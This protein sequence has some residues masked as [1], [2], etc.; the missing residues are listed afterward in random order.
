MQRC[1]PPAAS[2]VCSH[3]ASCSDSLPDCSL[4]L[5]TGGLSPAACKAT[6]SKQIEPHRVAVIFCGSALACCGLFWSA[7]RSGCHHPQV[8]RSH[9]YGSSHANS[10]LD[11][12]FSLP[13]EDAATTSGRGEEQAAEYTYDQE[14][15]DQKYETLLLKVIH[16]SRR[17]GFEETKDFPLHV[18]DLVAG[19]YQVTS[20]QQ[21]VLSPLHEGYQACWSGRFR[22][23]C[24]FPRSELR[25]CQRC[26]R[27]HVHNQV[28]PA[29]QPGAS[30]PGC[31]SQCTRCVSPA[32]ECLLEVAF[33]DSGTLSPDWWEPP[34]GACRSWTSWALPPSAGLC[35]RWTPRRAC[36]SA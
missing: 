4:L 20:A 34:P 24:A 26:C 10:L 15:I 22:W 2:M 3:R 33:G 30:P 8:W 11:G 1:L 18:N 7:C 5:P 29:V 27:A 12:W 13:A 9:I 28:Q 16:R 25:S 17:T 14:Y 36:W 19:R 23:P 21:S 31:S 32:W 6:R 35:R